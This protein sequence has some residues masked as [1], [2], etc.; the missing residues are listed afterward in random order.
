MEWPQGL[1]GLCFHKPIFFPLKTKKNNQLY[2]FQALAD[3]LIL[4]N[5]S[6]SKI[7]GKNLESH[8][9]PLTENSHF[10]LA[11]LR[12]LFFLTSSLKTGEII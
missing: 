2:A 4:C 1:A 10:L 6:I 7:L 3:A 11:S 9:N 12:V 5:G 8:L